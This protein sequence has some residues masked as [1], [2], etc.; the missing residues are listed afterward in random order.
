MRH[1]EHSISET[2]TGDTTCFSPGIALDIN[3]IT[4]LYHKKKILDQVSLSLETGK[5]TTILGPSGCGKT[6]LLRAIAGIEPIYQGEIRA[7]NTILSKKG[8]LIPTEKRNIGFVFQNYA[9]FPHMTISE[10]IIF[11]LQHIPW[12]KRKEE[13]LKRLEL[14]ELSRYKT[15]Y[16]HMLSGGEQQRV[17][18]T[19]CLAKQPDIILLDEPFSSLDGHLKDK[20]RENTLNQLQQ[21]HSTALMVTHDPVEALSISDKICLMVNGKIIQTGTP[22]EVYLNP[23]SPIAARL[24]GEINIWSGYAENGFIKTPFGTLEVSPSLDNK[25]LVVLTR[26][27]AILFGEHA[28]H[29]NTAQAVITDKKL[30]G[31]RLELTVKSKEKGYEDIL[32]HAHTALINAPQKGEII[33]VSLD[34]FFSHILVT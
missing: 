12:K 32:W 34:P 14:A 26:P 4:C 8:V 23:A 31:S 21:H 33:P 11:A 9:L 24:T 6:T 18:L 7:K 13:A 15:A 3:K 2:K 5:I 27:E 19:R 30:M 25:K 16:P 1:F 20:I 22:D 28:P 10:N 29:T 17:A